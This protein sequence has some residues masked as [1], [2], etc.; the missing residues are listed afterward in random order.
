MWTCELWMGSTSCSNNHLTQ[1]ASFL[2]PFYSDDHIASPWEGIHAKFPKP[3]YIIRVAIFLTLSPL[4]AAPFWHSR[5]MTSKNRVERGALRSSPSYVR[6]TASTRSNVVTSAFATG[7]FG[8]R[9]LSQGLA[10]KFS[11][12]NIHVALRLYQLILS[13][14]NF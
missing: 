4:P 13:R 1:A 10:K 2:V 6:R 9:A 3:E 14:F 12:E 5:R 11:K 7:K 8:A